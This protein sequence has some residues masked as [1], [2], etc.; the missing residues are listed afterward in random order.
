MKK[1]NII[2]ALTL[3]I[4]LGVGATTYAAS[5]PNTTV[6]A[7]T[8]NGYGIGRITGQRGSDFINNVLK[9][10]FGLS[11]T[12]IS[13]ARNS[14]KSMYELAKEKGIPDEQLKS[15]MIEEKTK[16]IDE[17]VKNGSVSKEDGDSLKAKI[18][19]NSANCP[20]PGQMKKGNGRGNCCGQRR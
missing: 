6:N 18:K 15:A 2:A 20:T 13:N 19:E 10:K 4:A 9:N 12:D 11:D 3:V 7:T 1:K 8:C 16:A 14:G 17:A 5:T